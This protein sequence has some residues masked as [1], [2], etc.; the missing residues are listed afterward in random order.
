M[1]PDGSSAIV[2][3][4]T[5]TV[6]EKFILDCRGTAVEWAAAEPREVVAEVDPKQVHVLKVLQTLKVEPEH[7]RVVAV[8]YR[9]GGAMQVDFQLRVQEQRI[10]VEKMPLHVRSVLSTNT[11][12]PP[13][14]FPP[15]PFLPLTYPAWLWWFLATGIFLTL[16]IP[17]LLWSQRWRRRRWVREVLDPEACTLQLIPRLPTHLQPY[18]QAGHSNHLN[19]LFRLL[20]RLQREERFSEAGAKTPTEILA[21]RK[22]TLEI[23][24]HIFRLY[25]TR[26]LRLPA[27]VWR[28]RRLSRQ[29]GNPGDSSAWQTE[30]IL[31][32]EELDKAIRGYQ[33]VTDDQ[34]RQLI[35]LV[36]KTAQVVDQVRQRGAR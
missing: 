20:R 18:T 35:H 11:A 5:Y 22:K 17:S 25:L 36:Q 31:T 28:V 8:S 12:Q 9:A 4:A 29:L 15:F 34:Y 3:A 2:E 10:S 33:K 14:P 13:Q 1:S 23:V 16:A 7:L 27:H 19:E 30:V 21:E 6:G 32:L 24:Q 26:Q